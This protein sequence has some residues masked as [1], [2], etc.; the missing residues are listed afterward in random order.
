MFAE[1]IE[2]ILR[3]Q[4]TPAVVRSIEGGGSPSSLWSAFSEAGFLDLLKSEAE[5]G[6][7]LP[8]TE[9]YPIVAQFATQCLCPWPRHW[10]RVGL[11]TTAWSSLA[12]C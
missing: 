5:G 8:L 2:D 3:D 6:A 10:R 12:E 11:S 7:E 9:L 1:A 4:C